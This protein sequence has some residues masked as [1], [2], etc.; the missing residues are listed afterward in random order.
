MIVQVKK[1]YRGLNPEMLYDEVRELV[2]Q[3]RP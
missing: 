1:T 2:A 3:A